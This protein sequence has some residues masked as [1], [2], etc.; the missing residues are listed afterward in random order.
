V[1]FEGELQEIRNDLKRVMKRFDCLFKEE[2]DCC[3]NSLMDEL[4]G[5]YSAIEAGNEKFGSA[6]DM[7][8]SQE[9]EEE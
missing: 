5:A 3:D 8:N 9:E 7:L 6:L 1:T 4:Q 2:R